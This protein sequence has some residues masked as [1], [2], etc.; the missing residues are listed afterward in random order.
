[1]SD[2][3]IDG[4]EKQIRHKGLCGTHYNRVRIYG[5]PH[6]FKRIRH[7]GNDTDRFWA[8]VQRGEGCWTW[9]AYKQKTGYGHFITADGRKHMAHRMA[10]ELIKG[11]IPEGRQL[12]HTCHNTSCV[13]PEHLRPATNKQNNENPGA[14]RSDNTSGYRG[15]RIEKRTGR[16]QTRAQHHG[17]QYTAGTFATAEEAAEAAR[18]LRL[19]LFT[20]NDADRKSA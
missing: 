11:P 5:D 10:Y 13:N 4:C 14:L 8:K 20:H 12:D 9:L 16:Y 7:M 6:A 1:M 18:Q 3:T 19:S 15:V 2:C 17:V